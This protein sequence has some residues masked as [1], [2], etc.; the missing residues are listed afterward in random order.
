MPGGNS[1]GGMSNSNNINIQGNVDPSEV[2]DTVDNKILSDTP[3]PTRN[4]EDR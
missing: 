2:W 1:T 3:E 4:H